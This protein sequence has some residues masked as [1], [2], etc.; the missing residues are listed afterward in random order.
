MGTG[1]SRVNEGSG[2][3]S[4]DVA[5]PGAMPISPLDQSVCH[6]HG[7][8]SERSREGTPSIT[9]T[10]RTLVRNIITP[11]LVAFLYSTDG[12]TN[13]GVNESI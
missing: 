1:T 10:E 11:T 5:S 7:E 8:P 2:S 6:D 12:M 3:A 4:V 13:E 9:I